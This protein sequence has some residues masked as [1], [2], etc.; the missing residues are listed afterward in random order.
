MELCAALGYVAVFASATNTLIAP[1]MIS[2]E[3]FGGNN[4]ILFIIVCIF[5]YLVN[6]NQSIY[7]AQMKHLD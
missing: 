5:A 6:G 1:M 3:V 4:M 2:I 7:G